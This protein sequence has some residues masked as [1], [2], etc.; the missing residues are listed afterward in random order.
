[1]RL[2]LVGFLILSIASISLAER[3]VVDP[4]LKL[5]TYKKDKSQIAGNLVAYDDDGFEVTNSKSEKSTIAWKELESKNVFQIH[6]RLLTKAS[7]DQWLVLA[8]QMVALPDG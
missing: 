2:A 1:M 7:G 5:L 4:P 3:I 6:E 8:Q